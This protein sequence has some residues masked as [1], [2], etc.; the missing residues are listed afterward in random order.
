M[1][2]ALLVPHGGSTGFRAML[3]GNRRVS[4]GDKLWVRCTK[5][6]LKASNPGL[7]IHHLTN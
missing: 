2:E 7:V 6:I 1:T 3:G 4:N 5:L